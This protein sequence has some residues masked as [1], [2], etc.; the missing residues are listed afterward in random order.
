MYQIGYIAQF[1]DDSD[2]FMS[3]M[4]RF[5]HLVPQRIMNTFQAEEYFTLGKIQALVLFL[6]E[7]HDQA[8]LLGKRLRSLLPDIPL[9]FIFNKI[10]KKSSQ[11]SPILNTAFLDKNYEIDDIA[12]VLIKLLFRKDIPLR[13]SRRIKGNY[14]ARIHSDDSQIHTTLINISSGGAALKVIDP[15]IY[16]SH[17]FKL[18]LI[19]KESKRHY[20]FDCE[21]AWKNQDTNTIGV[22]FARQSAA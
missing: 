2:K 4:N 8:I 11:S 15:R 16:E 19:S 17:D 7:L 10:D 21:I 6:P 12:G 20:F 13:S 1:E 5:R 9:I 3:I 18:H 14:E 22:K